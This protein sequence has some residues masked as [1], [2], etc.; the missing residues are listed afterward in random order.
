MLQDIAHGLHN[1]GFFETT[2]WCDDLVESFRSFVENERVE[3][4]VVDESG[5]EISSSFVVSNGFFHYSI[6]N[7]IL[8]NVVCEYYVFCNC[9]LRVNTIF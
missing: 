9:S 4:S 3:D 8:V 5:F 6:Y 1:K 7:G 2:N